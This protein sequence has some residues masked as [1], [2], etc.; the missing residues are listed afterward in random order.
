MSE[1]NVCYKTFASRQSLCNHRKRAHSTL[2]DAP[3]GLRKATT[4]DKKEANKVIDAIFQSPKKD[5]SPP[6]PKK[7]KVSKIASKIDTILN[8]AKGVRNTSG[9]KKTKIISDE[10]DSDSKDSNDSVSSSKSVRNSSVGKKTKI[11]SAESDSDS[12]DSNDSDSG[13]EKRPK[14]MKEQKS[15]LTNAFNKVYSSFDENDVEMRDDILKLLDALKTRGCVTK[16]EYADIKSH[17]ERRMHL[18]LYESIDST[19]E[20]MTQDDKNEVLELLRSMKDKDVGRLIALVKDYFEKEVELESVLLPARKLKDRLNALK[21]EIILKQIEKTRDRVKKI[22]TQLTSGTD[23]M[24]ILNNLRS[25]NLITDEQYEKLVIGPD[26]LPSISRIIQGKG[27]YLGRHW[28][29]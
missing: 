2:P 13:S 19:I 23:K 20:N 24:D 25:A 26:T 3:P 27:M 7:V 29:R 15:L 1:C 4:E 28:H 11:I 8:G 6:V 21:I 16:R 10:S 18:N 17:L 22:F 12:K 14:D 9:G 5:R